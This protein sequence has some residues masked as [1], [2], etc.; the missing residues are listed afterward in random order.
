MI[1]GRGWRQ[2]S[3]VERASNLSCIFKYGFREFLTHDPYIMVV[4]IFSILKILAKFMLPKTILY[5]VGTLS[6][7]DK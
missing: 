4:Q 2:R 3:V 6:H 7:L 5:L 1:G